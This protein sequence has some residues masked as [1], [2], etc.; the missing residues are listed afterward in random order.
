MSAMESIN[1]EKRPDAAQFDELVRRLDPDEDGKIT[2]ID[3]HL[4]V[5]EIDSDPRKKHDD[6]DDDGGG[7]DDGEAPPK[8]KRSAAQDS[9]SGR[10]NDETAGLFDA[11]QHHGHRV[12]ASAR[13]RLARAAWHRAERTLPSKRADFFA[14][15]VFLAPPKSLARRGAAH[16]ARRGARCLRMISEQRQP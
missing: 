7:D 12:A 2:V 1:F 6:D 4:L 11:K 13:E 3:L 5:S 14:V 15:H 16:T 9:Q 8:A 10:Q